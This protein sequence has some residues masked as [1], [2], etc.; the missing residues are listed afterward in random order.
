MAGVLWILGLVPI[1]QWAAALWGV[2]FHP[3]RVPLILLVALVGTLTVV[4]LRAVLSTTTPPPPPWLA[5]REDTFLGILWRWS[6]DG[7]HI[8]S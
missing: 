8:A 6:Y 2:L 3:V 5:Y 7:T 1:G 4:A